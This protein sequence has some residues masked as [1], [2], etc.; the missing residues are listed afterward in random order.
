MAEENDLPKIARPLN[1]APFAPSQRLA[2]DG[3]KRPGPVR[4]LRPGETSDSASPAS[5]LKGWAIFSH[6]TRHFPSPR[7]T[8][9]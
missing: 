5:A 4:F 9:L 8:P 1:T 6:S 3:K 2:R 7:R